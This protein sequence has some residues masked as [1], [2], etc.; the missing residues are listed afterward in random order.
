M[1]AFRLQAVLN[2]RKIEEEKIQGQLARLVKAVL[3][4]ERHLNFFRLKKMQTQRILHEKQKEGIRGFELTLYHAYLRELSDRIA[5]Q[6]S[7]LRQLENERDKVREKLIE[8]SKKR[9]MLEKLK[10][11]RLLMALSEEMRQHQNF[12]DEIGITRHTR[13]ATG[14][15]KG[16]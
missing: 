6:K 16:M 1:V 12:I 9:K 7:T 10:E 11:K 14:E 3:E 13:N 4:A 2:V 5:E 8:A 15:S